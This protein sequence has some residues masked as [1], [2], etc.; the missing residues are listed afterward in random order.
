[1][2]EPQ[3]PS[4]ES[5]VYTRRGNFAVFNQLGLK[6]DFKSTTSDKEYYDWLDAMIVDIGRL[7]PGAKIAEKS[8]ARAEPRLNTGV[9]YDTP[10]YRLLKGG[11]VLRTTCNR[12]THA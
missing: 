4:R 1:M 11:L 2:L 10:D 7:V 12:K 6:L 9:Y 8:Y 3:M 5:V